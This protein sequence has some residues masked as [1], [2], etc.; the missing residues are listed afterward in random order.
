MKISSIFTEQFRNL[1]KGTD[2][3]NYC[4]YKL[5]GEYNS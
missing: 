4:F 1:Q 3:F 5:R 2:V